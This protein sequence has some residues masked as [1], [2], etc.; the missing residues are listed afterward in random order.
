[1][2]ARQTYQG[3]FL[4]PPSTDITSRLG[5][6]RIG[7]SKQSLIDGKNFL[8]H[9][10]RLEAIERCS[11]INGDLMGRDNGANLLKKNEVHQDSAQSETSVHSG[12]SNVDTQKETLSCSKR[13]K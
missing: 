11:P 7:Y 4:S 13:G 6:V 10:L 2:F 5:S 1:M 12:E 8:S 9:R 3:N